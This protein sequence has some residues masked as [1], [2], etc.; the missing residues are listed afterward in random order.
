VPTDPI[1]GIVDAFKFHPIVALG[2]GN[3]G[4]LQGHAFRLSLLRDPRFQQTVN[5]IVVEFGNSRYQEMVDRFVTGSDIPYKDLRRIWIDTTQ[6]Q[7]VWDVPIYEEFYRAVREVNASLPKSRPLRVLLGDAAIDWNKVHSKEDYNNQPERLDSSVADLIEREVLNRKR[8]ALVIYGDVH[9]LRKKVVWK[10]L[11]GSAPA[12]DTPWS[13]DSI[14]AS[15][16]RRGYRVFSINTNVT[17]DL[18]RLQPSIADWSH[19]KLI[20]LESNLLGV[21]PYTFYYDFP[22]MGLRRDGTW[23]IVGHVDKE[24]SS[25]MQEQFDAILYLGPRSSIRYSM[26]S[27]TLCDD[28]EYLAIRLG[29]LRMLAGEE[30]VKEIEDYCAA[31]KK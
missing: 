14:V 22:R 11:E 28:A 7:T 4:N 1:A 26:P 25:L 29:R 2:E 31:R 13:E 8:R 23:D 9:F 12:R 6:V 21:A 24:H 5:D 30:R 19:P 20:L 3:H 10:W 17:A 27:P 15:L 16:E 18:T